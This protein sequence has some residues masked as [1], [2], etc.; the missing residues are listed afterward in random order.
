M[1][2]SAL[3]VL[4]TGATTLAADSPRDP[5]LALT[6]ALRAE[7]PAAIRAAVATGID[8]LGE[9]AGEPE[10][11]DHYQPVPA[12]ARWLT[13]AEAQRGFAP[14]LD[15]L[16]KRVWWRVGLDPAKLTE[17][18]RAPASVLTG[19]V[20][21][22]RARLD[23]ADRSLALAKDAAEFLL[24]TQAQAGSGVFPF[25]AARGPAKNRAME[26]GAAFLAA[27]ERKG[28]LDRVVKNGWVIEDLGDGGLQFD[29]AECG[30]AMFEYY[31]LTADPRAL[32]SARRAADW[33]ATR[34][35]VPNWNY[36]S[37]SVWLLAKAHAVTGD[38]AYLAAAKRKAL[39]GV[40]PGQLTTGPHSGRWLDPHNARP[41]Y[42][43]IMLRALA[44]LAAELPATDPDRPAILRALKLGLVTRN[45]EFTTRGVMN[46][47]NALETLLLVHQRFAAEPGF[48]AGTRST[49][50]LDALARAASARALQGRPALGP[51][52]LGPF[53]AYAK[54]RGPQP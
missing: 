46:E 2:L 27:A 6:T 31:E 14:H 28:Q 11:A 51:R 3:I 4:L 43:Y 25:P 5:R 17:A 38:A 16:Q 26:A 36:N 47:D 8:L 18:L 54:A 10:I 21:V 41:A 53:L 50:A 19:C 35:L 12:D 15:A 23:G 24:W 13:P 9:R 33:A 1:R 34:P 44:L 48:L 49:T 45:A 39:L 42:H 22:A 32:A 29:H 7:D 40:I 30:V 52:A 20:A 37:F